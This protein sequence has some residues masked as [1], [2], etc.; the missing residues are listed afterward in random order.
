MAR[1]VLISS[2]RDCRQNFLMRRLTGCLRTKNFLVTKTLKLGKIGLNPE[3][4]DNLNF[5]LSYNRQLGKHGL[6]VETGLIYRNTSD[7]IYRSIETTSNRSYGSYSNYGSVE[8]KG[9]HISA[10][11]NYSCWVSIG[12]NFTQ[13]DVRDNVEKTQTG[14]ESLTYGA[15]MPNLPYRFAN[16][17]ISFFWR[18][19]WKKGKY[20]DR[21]L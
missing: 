10:R 1:P 7:Y 11:Y 16:S 15:R 13:M 12:G 21:Y 2:F 3:K 19:L 17:D 14:Q 9:Y 18:N 8:T 20:A 6:Y 5:N 4:S